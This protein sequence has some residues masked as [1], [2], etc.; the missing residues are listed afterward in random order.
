MKKLLLVL[1]L[2]L[3]GCFFGSVPV[4]RH[5]P[6]IPVDL[7]QACPDLQQLDTKTTKLSD[8]VSNVSSNYSEYHECRTKVDSWV[9]WYGK[10]KQIFEEVK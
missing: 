9:E 7:K 1:P 3:S 4:E 8:V 5:F 2:L 10:Q 6:E